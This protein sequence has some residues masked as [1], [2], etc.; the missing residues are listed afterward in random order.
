M[1]ANLQDPFAAMTAELGVG[2]TL[3]IGVAS[4]DGCPRERMLAEA[5]KALYRS[6]DMGREAASPMVAPQCRHRSG[7]TSWMRAMSSVNRLALGANL[8]S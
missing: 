4:S 5:D 3:S 7:R 1:A 6:K 2:T 8:A